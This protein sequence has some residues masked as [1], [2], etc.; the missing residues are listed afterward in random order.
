LQAAAPAAAFATPFGPSRFAPFSANAG[1][2]R[3]I[4]AAGTPRYS[5]SRAPRSSYRARC[6]RSCGVSIYNKPDAVPDMIGI[7]VGSLDDASMFKP[8]IVVYAARGPAWDFLDPDIPRL[9]EWY[10]PLT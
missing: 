2:A 5:Y 8:G 3:W 7:Y 9:P 1:I 10:P 4:P 6:A